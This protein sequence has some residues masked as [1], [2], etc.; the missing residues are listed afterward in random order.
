MARYA[1][2]IRLVVLD[3]AGT[4]CDGPQD[5]RHLYPN[6]D[7]KAVKSPV[8]CFEKVLTKRKI[9]TDWP[10]LRKPMGLF[11]KQ[12][13]EQLLRDETI[14]S[15]WRTVYHRDWTQAD[16]D[17]MFTE[18]RPLAREVAVS[19]ELV[20]PID[21][22]KEAIDRLR[23]AGIAIGC[24]TGYP[25]EA[26]NA[27]YK[28]LAEQYD[29][30][31]DVTADSE[32]VAGRPTP[33]L[34][35]DCMAKANVYPPQA[36]VKADDV[37]AGIWEGNNSGAWTAGIYA[38]GN[39]GYETLAAAKPDYLIPSLRYLPDIVFGQIQPRVQRGEL[40]GQSL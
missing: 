35:Y 14:A 7:G 39:D 10:T 20:R 12:H 26:A 21:G 33:F 5:L 11:K 30:R 24:D 8:I 6:D 27:V 28:A 19:K 40:P 38:T 22:V 31:F 15:Q 1:G 36:V 9:R 16:L 37:A 32:M 29:I 25:A 2:G 4:V 34:V 23:E 13:L 17:E 3:L 18:F